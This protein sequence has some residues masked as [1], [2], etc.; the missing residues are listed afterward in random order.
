MSQTGDP[1]GSWNLYDVG[2]S[3]GVL[4]DQPFL[5]VSDDKVTISVNDIGPPPTE[6]FLG[7]TTYVV[8][9]GEADA[10][11]TPHIATLG[12]A[13]LF[14][15]YSRPSPV[16]STLARASATTVN[17]SSMCP[18]SRYTSAIETWYPVQDISAPMADSD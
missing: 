6:P 13:P 16:R 11:G 3:T 8:N 9:K 14:D 12:A 2:T 18:A 17:P 7:S 4:Q 5:G 15:H 1:T 10:G